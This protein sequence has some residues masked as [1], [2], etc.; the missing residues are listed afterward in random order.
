MHACSRIWTNNNYTYC[1]PIHIVYYVASYCHLIHWEGEQPHPGIADLA[2]LQSHQPEA[3]VTSSSTYKVDSHFTST[4]DNRSTNGSDYAKYKNNH[5]SCISEQWSIKIPKVS[6]FEDI[7]DI[8]ETSGA[9]WWFITAITIFIN[10][11]IVQWSFDA[12]FIV[13]VEAFSS[14]DF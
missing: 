8:W 4:H 3:P 2:Q 7:I 10:S 5:A 12:P 14:A 6:V 1:K 9:G 13:T 11:I